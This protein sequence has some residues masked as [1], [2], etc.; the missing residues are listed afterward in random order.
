[1]SGQKR[2]A[3]T[4]LVESPPCKK[5]SV[6]T[7]TVDKWIAKNNKALNT[8]WLKYDWKDREYVA[9]LKCAVIK[10]DFVVRMYPQRHLPSWA[11]KH[12]GEQGQHDSQDVL[13]RKRYPVSCAWAIS[14]GGRSSNTEK[15]V[16]LEPDQNLQPLSLRMTLQLVHEPYHFRT[17]KRSLLEQHYVQLF[18]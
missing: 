10:I 17:G 15:W 2:P 11:H 5:C 4:E 7:M 16:I 8:T 12:P 1:M 9:L 3:G 14:F 18:L 6:T 13:L